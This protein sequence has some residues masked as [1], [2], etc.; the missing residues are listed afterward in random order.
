M[1]SSGD[2]ACPLVRQL[3]DQ[4]LTVI[5]EEMKDAQTLLKRM[6][7]ASRN[8]SQLPDRAPSGESICHLI[9]TWDS[10]DF[11][12]ENTTNSSGIE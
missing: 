6:E 5:R 12:D 9:E 10:T 4:R 7:S 8:W 3:I 2:T 1:A 11:F